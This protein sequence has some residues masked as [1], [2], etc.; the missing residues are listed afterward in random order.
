M[1]L[2][3]KSVI[4]DLSVPEFNTLRDVCQFSNQTFNVGLNTVRLHLLVKLSRF[5]GC[6][7]RRARTRNNRVHNGLNKIS[8]SI[9]YYGLTHQLGKLTIGCNPAWKPEINLSKQNTFQFVQ[10]PHDVLWFKLKALSKRYGIAYREREEGDLSSRAS[11]LEPDERPIYKA[12][13]PQEDKL[14]ESFI[15]RGL[16]KSKNYSFIHADC[17]GAANILKK[18]NHNLDFQRVARGIF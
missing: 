7:T 8:R 5:T 4:R 10:I 14:S 1:F 6:P 13:N 3:Q 18:S 12:D 11:F 9:I 2:T 16:Y 17:N 15:C